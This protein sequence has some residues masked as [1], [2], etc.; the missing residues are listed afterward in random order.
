MP[1]RR[2]LVKIMKTNCDRSRNVLHVAPKGWLLFVGIL[3]ALLLTFR[4]HYSVY[5]AKGESMLPGLHSGDLVLVDKR[6]YCAQ[7]PER[8]DIVVAREGDELL[9]KRIVGLPGEVVEL[10]QGKVYVNQH[11]LTESYVTETGAL[12]LRKDRLWENRYAL[13]GDNRAVSR[14]VFVHAV[15]AE[16]QIVGKAIYSVRLWPG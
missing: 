16:E 9:V 7:A 12:N 11:P 13:L 2:S 1:P 6:A 10:R 15:V 8:G 3:L 14:S 4:A 5:L